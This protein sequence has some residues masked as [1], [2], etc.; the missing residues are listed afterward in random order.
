MTKTAR[1]CLLD[2]FE[3][4]FDEESVEVPKTLQR[5]LAFLGLR[6]QA[7]RAYTIG[8]LWP[9]SGEQK[10]L[11]SLRTALWRLHQA[12]APVVAAKGETLRLADWVRVDVDELE[13]SARHVAPDVAALRSGGL[14]ELLPGW[15]DDWVLLERERLRQLYLHTLEKLAAAELAKLTERR[16]SL[17]KTALGE[18]GIADLAALRAEVTT[19]DA[20]L[21]KLRG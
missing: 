17:L 18:K 7:T 5:L 20:E 10:A 1:L 6:R 13:R 8:A 2:G 16:D 3:L 12:G 9:E 21:A 14:R 15:Y 11:G 4:A 19:T